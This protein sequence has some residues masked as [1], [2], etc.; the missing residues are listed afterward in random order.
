MLCIVLSYLV[1]KAAHDIVLLHVKAFACQVSHDLSDVGISF[2]PSLQALIVWQP[3]R[4]LK[5]A[6]A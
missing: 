5:C 1:W 4:Q 6:C 2:E 3:Q